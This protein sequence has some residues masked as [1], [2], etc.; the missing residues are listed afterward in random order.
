MINWLIDQQVYIS[1]TLCL[2]LIIESK[3]IS[4]LGPKLSYTLWL[5]F[6][7]TLI[8]NQLAQNL[9]IIENTQITRYLVEL[10]HQ[11]LTITKPHYWQIIWGLGALVVL[12][13]GFFSRQQYIIVKSLKQLR[14][15]CL[16]L[17]LPGDL[18]VY[19]S[20]YVSSPL[21]LGLF[22]PK[23]VLPTHY[24]KLYSANQLTMILEHELYHLSRKDNMYN[25][26][27]IILL[28]VFWF[29]P[30][31]WFGYFSFR[32]LQEI[33]CDNEVLKS[34]NK[35]SRIEYSKALLICV[36][37]S[38][39]HLYSYS[40]YT[41]K[42]TMLKRL[43]NIKQQNTTNP[44]SQLLTVLL[45]ISLLSG[46][47]IAHQADIGIK[48]EV[49]NIHPIMRIEPKYPPQAVADNLEGSVLLKFDVTPSGAVDNL[50]VLSSEPAH[51]FDQV[52]MDALAQWRYET[53]SQGQKSA[54]VQLDFVLSDKTKSVNLVEQI[55]ATH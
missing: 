23:L 29:N 22:F 20:K 10:N 38:Q 47:A 17:T 25:G 43:N 18:A 45:A 33:S 26:L 27:A 28:S 5:I 8:L 2:L 42:Q 11:N 14:P 40:H 48:E 12:L 41:E 55:K 53:S 30:L 39:N 15:Q 49:K 3:L 32:R 24:K 1:I 54:T 16:P 31:M 7:L 19:E 9:I 6:P 37:Q 52:A 51:I 21:L 50:T 44:F 35:T 34:K 4:K 13:T 36:E 46:V